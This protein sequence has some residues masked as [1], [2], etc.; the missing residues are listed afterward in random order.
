MTALKTIARLIVCGMFA[1]ISAG[2]CI[3]LADAALGDML[4]G[5]VISP[6]FALMVGCSVYKTIG[7]DI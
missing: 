6:M 3:T 1:L 4:A 7:G 2:G 5:L